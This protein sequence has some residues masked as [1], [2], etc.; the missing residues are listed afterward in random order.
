MSISLVKSRLLLQN[1][2][3]ILEYSFSHTSDEF[4]MIYC[5]SGSV[6]LSQEKN[7]IDIS[8]KRFFIG[9]LIAD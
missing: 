8:V 6:E 2:P 4:G 9:S 1:K 3:S 7:M 5:S